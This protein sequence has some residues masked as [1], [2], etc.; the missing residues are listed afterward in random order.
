[1]FTYNIEYLTKLGILDYH[2]FAEVVYK[3]KK[4]SLRGLI[5]THMPFLAG[6]E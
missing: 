2:E 6:P 1:M 3:T 4:Q 5:L